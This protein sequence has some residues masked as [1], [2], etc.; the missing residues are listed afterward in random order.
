[1]KKTNV[2]R[3]GAFLLGGLLMAACAEPLIEQ[4]P[5]EE[6][7]LKASAESVVLDQLAEQDEALRLTWGAGSNEGTGAAIRYTLEMDLAGNDFAGGMKD[8]LG[9]TDVHFMAFSHGELNDT[10]L[11]EYWGIDPAEVMAFGDNYNDVSMLDA[12]GVPCLMQTAAQELLERYPN[13]TPCPEDTI[14][15][16]LDSLK[17]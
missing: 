11:A 3:A 1:M 5:A 9:K 6:L 12:V 10:I 14:Q 13:H 8:S 16:L 2:Y 4:K 7:T 17:D 15:T